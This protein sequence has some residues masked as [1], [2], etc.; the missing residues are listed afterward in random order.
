MIS[1]FP[2]VPPHFP[3]GPPSHFPFYEMNPMMGGPVFAFGPHDESAST[4]QS[5]PQKTTA[6]T[7][8]PIGGWQ[9]GHSGVELLW[10]SNRI[11][12]TFYC[13]AWRI[14]GVQGPPHM[15]VYNHFAP[16]GQFGQVGL[17]FMGTTYI[18][19]G[20]Q[21]GW[22]HIPTTSAAGTSEGNMNNMNYDIFSEESC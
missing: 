12:W 11:Y 1:H 13:S 3:S 14:P 17:S 8:R 5:Q 2:A 4:T 21:P 7:S 10:S 18:P 15:I 20:K 22:K 9:Q 6:P 19:S 16:V